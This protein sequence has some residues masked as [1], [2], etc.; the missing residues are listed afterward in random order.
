MLTEFGKELRKIRL[1]RVERQAE[2]ARKIGVSGSFLSV[3]ELGARPIPSG[4]E[5]QIITACELTPEQA[6][7]LRR[8]TTNSRVAFMLRKHSNLPVAI[9]SV[10]VQRWPTLEDD[11][12]QR[13]LDILMTDEADK[14]DEAEQ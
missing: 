14:T 10:L 11:Q 1:D 8:A 2:M 4:F 7:G 12:L 5:E 3:V 6:E 9:M 13:I